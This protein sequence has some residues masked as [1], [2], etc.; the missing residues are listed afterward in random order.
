MSGDYSVAGRKVKTR[1]MRVA[2]PARVRQL[3]IALSPLAGF[4]RRQI[5]TAPKAKQIIGICRVPF[6][7]NFLIFPVR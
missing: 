5:Q 2:S 4:A 6:P 1:I 3:Q 7:I